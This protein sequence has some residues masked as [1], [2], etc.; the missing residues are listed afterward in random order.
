MIRVINV[1][2]EGKVVASKAAEIAFRAQM[3]GV[4]LNQIKNALKNIFLNN[5]LILSW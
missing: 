4:K 2:S 3:H 1:T 5:R